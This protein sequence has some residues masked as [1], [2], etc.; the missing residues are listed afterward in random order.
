MFQL[1]LELAN[2]KWPKDAFKYIYMFQLKAL[3]LIVNPVF[4]GIQIHLYVSVKVVFLWRL[5]TVGNGFKYI[6]MFQL[7]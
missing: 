3:T 7:K 2:I 1:K 4:L 6:Y 5:R